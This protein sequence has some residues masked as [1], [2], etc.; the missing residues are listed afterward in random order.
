METVGVSSIEI[1]SYLIH[2]SIPVFSRQKGAVYYKERVFALC[3]RIESKHLFS[4]NL[5]K[6][7]CKKSPF[8]RALIQIVE[9]DFADGIRREFI[10]FFYSIHC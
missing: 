8:N 4:P 6:L 1:A 7:T 3:K 10:I 2:G 9:E 5:Y